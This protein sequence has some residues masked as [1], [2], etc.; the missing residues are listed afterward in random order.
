MFNRGARASGVRAGALSTRSDAFVGHGHAPL[1]GSR[2]GPCVPA[3]S[4]PSSHPDHP[5]PARSCWGQRPA[6]PRRPL[7][8]GEPLGREPQARRPE[9]LVQRGNISCE[10]AL[11]V[12]ADRLGRAPRGSRRTAPGPRALT[13]SCPHALMTPCPRALVPSSQVPARPA[14]GYMS[15]WPLGSSSGPRGLGG[16]IITGCPQVTHF[17]SQP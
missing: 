7:L 8:P 1:P 2:L 16:P 14:G 4:E 10:D 5:A 17:T 6:R 12:P 13:P 11:G 15:T 9:V 3:A